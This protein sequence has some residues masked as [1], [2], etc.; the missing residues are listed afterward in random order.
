MCASCDTERKWSALCLIGLHRW[1]P[2]NADGLAR[3][4]VCLQRNLVDVAWTGAIGF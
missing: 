2:Q 3:Y 1:Q 4:K